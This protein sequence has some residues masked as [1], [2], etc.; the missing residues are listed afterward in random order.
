MLNEE[1]TNV[2][3][4]PLHEQHCPATLVGL[5]FVHAAVQDPDVVVPPSFSPEVG[6]SEI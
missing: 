3:V 2:F 4:T 1:R 6:S 5:Y